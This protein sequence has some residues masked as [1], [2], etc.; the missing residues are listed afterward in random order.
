[1]I[2]TI[3]Y[4]MDSALS[5]AEKIRI[6]GNNARNQFVARDDT[7]D[8]LVSSICSAEHMIM[9]GGVGTAKSALAR[10][11]SDSMGLKFYKTNM[12][13]DLVREHL[14]GPNSLQALRKDIWKIKLA[15]LATSDFALIDEVGK[16]SGNVMNMLLK[17]FE[18]RLVEE[19]PDEET[20]IPL[21]TAI[22][23]SNETF[24]YDS[25]AL[26]DRFTVRV[27]VKYISNPRDFMAML[28]TQSDNAVPIEITREELQNLRNTLAVTRYP[29]EIKTLLTEMWSEFSNVINAPDG[30][31]MVSDRRWKKILKVATGRAFSYGSDVVREEDLTVARWILWQDV[32]DIEKIDDW[33]DKRINAGM[34]EILNAEERLQEIE[35]VL[36]QNITDYNEK[37]AL[38]FKAKKL[39][40]EAD[41]AL[42]DKTVRYRD[43]WEKVL[44]RSIAVGNSVLDKD[45][46][47]S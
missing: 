43:R 8:A 31:S 12:N 37:S 41:K 39:E 28:D 46:D 47:D 32:D 18:E 23:A 1:M 7:I 16:A 25:P 2:S 24:D 45:G 38:I 27:V 35:D 5:T 26:W 13:P 19:S 22:G 20:A 6:I 3:T 36:M 4:D 44:Q 40:R 21:H 17:I 33:V 15:G 14:I 34:L 30:R 10:Y 11:F 29:Q 42:R 9:L